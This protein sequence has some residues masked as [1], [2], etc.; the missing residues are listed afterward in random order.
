MEIDSLEYTNP[1]TLQ[2]IELEIDRI[3]HTARKENKKDNQPTFLLWV[4][5]HDTNCWKDP[6]K[7]HAN[8]KRNKK[9]R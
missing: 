5:N 9:I 8:E 1:K 2:R 6:M 4:F 3:K 7:P